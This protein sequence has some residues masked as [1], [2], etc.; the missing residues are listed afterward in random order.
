MYH[1]RTWLSNHV[2]M[3]HRK[4]LSVTCPVDNQDSWLLLIQGEA[5]GFSLDTHISEIY[6]IYIRPN[7]SRDTSQ[8]T[9]RDNICTAWDWGRHWPHWPLLDQSIEIYPY[10][11][12]STLKITSILIAVPS[13]SYIYLKHVLKWT[14]CA[15]LYRHGRKL[16]PMPQC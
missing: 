2:D 1:K 13:P 3:F 7:G 8:W 10:R 11:E 15:V 14:R 4:L 9:D 12:W 5:T 16:R 6:Q